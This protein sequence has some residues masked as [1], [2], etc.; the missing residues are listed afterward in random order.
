MVAGS[1]F[2]RKIN[3]SFQD[4]YNGIFGITDVSG[5]LILQKEIKNMYI[6][7]IDLI[8]Q[9]G[10]YICRFSDDQGNVANKKIVVID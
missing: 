7:E 6:F 1:I 9:K 8:N 5:R 4:V 10:V 3:I 2:K